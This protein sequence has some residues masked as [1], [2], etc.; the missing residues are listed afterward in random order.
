MY[1]NKTIYVSWFP[2]FQSKKSTSVSDNFNAGLEQR[3][4][5]LMWHDVLN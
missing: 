2:W 4:R 1:N 3:N 5:T